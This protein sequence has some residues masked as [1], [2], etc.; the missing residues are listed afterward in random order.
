VTRP[1]RFAVIGDPIAHSKSPGMHGAAYAAL[2]LPHVYEALRVPP[3]D[4]ARAMKELADGVYAGFN[5]TVPHKR[6]VMAHVA[7]VSPA[8]ERAGAANTIERAGGGRLVAHNTD[9]PALA[10]ELAA[11]APERADWRTA[12][13][14]VLGT[15]GVARAAVVA[16]TGDL[17][18][19]DVMVRGRS[20]GSLGDLQIK[21]IQPLYA[22]YT[23]W[24][25]DLVVQA[26]SSGMAGA[27]S[28]HDVARA[29]DWPRLPAHAVVLET[30]YAPKETPFLAHARARGLRCANGLGM[31]ARQGALA[32]EIW[33]GQKPPLDVMLGAISN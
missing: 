30:I 4:L 31:L 11:L 25:F 26:T 6:A 12:R 8:A 14:L 18:V 9:V 5:V 13:A 16:L 20:E 29:V 32:F 10:A 2:G 1:L 15:G 33:L 27:D 19:A 24:N 7:E 3:Q 23:D 22:K 21:P 28:G 17:A